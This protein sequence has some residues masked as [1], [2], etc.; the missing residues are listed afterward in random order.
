MTLLAERMLPVV[1]L[2]AREPDVVSPSAASDAALL[3][4]LR[5][6]DD[7]ALGSLYDRFGALVFGLAK[8]VARDEQIAREVTQDVFTYLWEFPE[9]ADLSRGSLRSY[10][11]V[12]AHRRSVDA[13]RRSERRQGAENRAGAIADVVAQASDVVV[14]TET[15]MAWRRNRLAE[16]MGSLPKDQRDALRLAYFEG[17]TYRQVAADLDI[18]EGTAKS[19]L[20]LA[21]ERLREKLESEDLAAWT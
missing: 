13:V 15:T 21:L 17:R 14:L 10:I 3:E 5:A 11:G 16:L 9:R 7:G 2:R 8:S 18:P 12:L 6:G 20:R 4:R 19:R 1:E